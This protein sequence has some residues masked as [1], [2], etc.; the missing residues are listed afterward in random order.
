MPPFKG[1]LTQKQ[2]QDVATY[3]VQQITHGS[4]K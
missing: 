2:I 4:T 1:Q 3:V